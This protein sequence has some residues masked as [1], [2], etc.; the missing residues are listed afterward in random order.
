MEQRPL[1][2]SGLQVPVIG[3]G[4]WRT[5]DTAEDRAPLAEA[6]ISA[7]ITLF[8]S[9]P[10]YGRAEGVLA[11]ALQ[12]RRDQVQVATKIWTESADEGRRQAENA[13]RLFGHVDIYQV[14]NLVSWKAQLKLLEGLRETGQVSVVGAT[15]YQT[16]A[17]PELMGR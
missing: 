12:G 6:A 4:T 14:H 15:H 5:F 3:M 10:M 11:A 8:D 9:S 16:S 17:F 2:R 13:L 7:G 1:G